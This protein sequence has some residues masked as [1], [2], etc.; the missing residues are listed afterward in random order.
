MNKFEKLISDHNKNLAEAHSLE[1]QIEDIKKKIPSVSAEVTALAAA[2]R[3]EEYKAKHA[4]A[5]NLELMIEMMKIQIE[6]LRQPVPE[7]QLQAAW[8]DYIVEEQKKLDKKE[9]AY[10]KAEEQLK[11]ACLDALAEQRE[12]LA[13]S[14]TLSSL[15]GKKTNWAATSRTLDQGKFNEALRFLRSRAAITPEASYDLSTVIARAKGA[16]PF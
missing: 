1:S 4:E 14:K 12:V 9:K 16:L 6:N 7:E 13:A 15:S 10:E 11:E 2:G 8:D 3:F 5:D